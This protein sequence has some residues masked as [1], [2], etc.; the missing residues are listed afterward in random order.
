MR[1]AF[2]LRL[3]SG[4]KP[5]GREFSGRIEEVDT[6]N[7]RHFDSTEEMLT[8]LESCLEDAQRRE[9]CEDDR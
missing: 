3:E 6:G 7:E 9:Q 4:R 5:F 1:S 2:V 8:F